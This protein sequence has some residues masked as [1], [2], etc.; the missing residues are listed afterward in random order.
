MGRGRQAATP[1]QLAQLPRCA[2]SLLTRAGLRARAKSSRFFTPAHCLLGGSLTHGF[3]SRLDAPFQS[4]IDRVILA[5]TLTR[6][7]LAVDRRTLLKTLSASAIGAAAVGPSVFS[8][9]RA[10]AFGQAPIGHDS[11]LLPPERRAENVLEIFLY[12]GISQYES[13]Y[14]VPEHGKA[15]GT[16]YHLY[17]NSGDVQKAVDSC[18]L[19]GLDLTERFGQDALGQD[20]HLGPYVVPLRKRPDMVERMRV[21]ITHHDLEPHEAAI[22]LMLG[23]RGLGNPALCGLGAHIQRYYTELNSLPARGP[24]AWV[25]LHSSL[26]AFPTDNLRTASA[27]GLHPGSAR[28]L[29]LKIDSSGELTSLL[30]RAT[31]GQ[32]RSAHDALLAANIARYHERLVRPNTLTAVRAPRLTELTDAASA[33]RDSE[34]VAA[35]LEESL[36][37]KQ[38]ISHC[39]QTVKV[40]PI[41][42]NLTMAAH[43][44]TH[45]TSPARYVCVIDGGLIPA[46]GGGGYDTHD[47]NPHTQARNLSHTLNGLC[48]IINGPDEHDPHKLDLDK[49]LIVLTTEFGRTPFQQGKKGR[50]HWPYGFPVVFIGGP[51][52]PENK[53]IFGACGP[54]ARAVTGST[55]Q[56]NRI[57]AL[58]AL[59]IWPFANESFNVADVPDALSEPDAVLL[60][61][62]RQL[63]YT[64]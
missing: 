53:G 62:K 41:T 21:A 31:L 7:E 11:I 8:P 46:D 28:P 54:D 44:L 16:H 3:A 6:E 48:A 2:L 20:V 63:G 18:G 32:H 45:P 25:L 64:A 50:N 43:L 24:K 10:M 19:V 27:I 36:F 47:E 49:T 29:A 12:G 37:V 42:M 13:F 59:G 52:R 34:Q 38:G 23:G 5:R 26:G 22:P 55:P 33:V 60:V 39:G 14:C 40:D 15:K 51:I 61:L 30:A 1:L 35:M 56:E 17:L 57:A 4:R 9:R 58:L